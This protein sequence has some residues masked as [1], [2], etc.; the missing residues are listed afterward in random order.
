M[1]AAGDSGGEDGCRLE[2]DQGPTEAS[3]AGGSGS[4]WRKMSSTIPG[5]V[6]GDWSD[7]R[8]RSSQGLLARS[9]GRRALRH[10]SSSLSQLPARI[11]KPDKGGTWTQEDFKLQMAD[12]FGPTPRPRAGSF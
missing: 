11:K 9:G 3:A 12:M 5:D 2:A 6:D 4:G 10:R 7:H 8:T 1:V